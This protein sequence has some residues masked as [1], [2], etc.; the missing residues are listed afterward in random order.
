M[1][2]KP[3]SP[4]TAVFAWWLLPAVAVLFWFD[5]A[6]TTVWPACPFHWLTGWLCPL[7]GSLR[8]AHLALHGQVLAAFRANALTCGTALALGIVV[9]SR[10][11]AHALG[12]AETTARH[13][14]AIGAAQ[15]RRI[16][17]WHAALLGAIVVAFTVARNMPGGWSTWLRP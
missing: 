11:L 12:D 6:V 16:R 5:P 10:V 4:R 17:S 13:A 1:V 3:R 2:D 14:K 7:C 8:A 15:G 9:G